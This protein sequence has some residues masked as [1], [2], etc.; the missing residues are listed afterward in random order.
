M[1][2]VHLKY[3]PMQNLSTDRQKTG[4]LAPRNPMQNV[5]RE[6]D[7][8]Q[9][10]IPNPPYTKPTNSVPFDHLKSSASHQLDIRPP[11]SPEY[12]SCRT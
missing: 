3:P 7:P 2:C 9:K 8:E 1:P 5:Q 6:N 11:S 4:T 10:T 12:T